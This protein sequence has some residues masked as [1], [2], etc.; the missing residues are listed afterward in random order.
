KPTFGNL[1]AAVSGTML[2]NDKSKG[3]A[4]RPAGG[5]ALAAPSKFAAP[6]AGGGALKQAAK[7]LLGRLPLISDLY[8][9]YWAFPRHGTSCRGAYES[10]EQAS[11]ALPKTRS[12]GHGAFAAKVEETGHSI[13]LVTAGVEIGE[14][15][16]DDARA[17]MALQTA[18]CTGR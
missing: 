3:R 9:Y 10:F 8:Q 12:V 17:A 5:Q 4:Q 6:A 13:S 15:R 1:K 16:P 2:Q 11:A 14:F 18:L 7:T